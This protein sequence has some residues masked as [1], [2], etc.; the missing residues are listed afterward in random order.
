MNA[1]RGQ[2]RGPSD[3]LAKI[4]GWVWNRRRFWLAPL[5]VAL[6]L[7]LLLWFSTRDASLPAFI[8]EPR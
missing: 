2:V 7:F 8:Y 1:R 6:G 5:L 3:A 4:G